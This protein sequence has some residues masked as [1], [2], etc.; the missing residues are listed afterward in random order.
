MRVYAIRS[1]R[2][3]YKAGGRVR[4]G[5]LPPLWAPL[6]ARA[7]RGYLAPGGFGAVADPPRSVCSRSDWGDPVCELWSGWVCCRLVCRGSRTLP[8]CRHAGW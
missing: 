5:P 8:M 2:F 1:D 6:P 3:L 7:M 4:S